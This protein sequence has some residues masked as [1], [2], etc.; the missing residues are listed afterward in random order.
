MWWWFVLHLIRQ[1]SFISPEV[2]C[3]VLCSG[4]RLNGSVWSTLGIVPVRRVGK[5]NIHWPDFF[6]FLFTCY[7]LCSSL[8][9]S[10][11]VITFIYY[12]HFGS[13]GNLT[14]LR[15][16]ILKCVTFTKCY[17]VKNGST[18]LGLHRFLVSLTL[19]ILVHVAGVRGETAGAQQPSIQGSKAAGKTWS[20]CRPTNGTGLWVWCQWW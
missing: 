3:C 9:D 7:T 14:Q 5:K 12:S 20:Q 16:N 11:R 8:K 15:L 1:F 6:T 4:L 18:G 13:W 10:C 19:V 17:I 2:L